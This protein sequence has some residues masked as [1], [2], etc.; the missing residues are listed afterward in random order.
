MNDELSSFLF[1]SSLPLSLSS[2]THTHTHT[3][4]HAFYSDKRRRIS[5]TNGR[6]RERERKKKCRVIFSSL[7][8]E[9]G[10]TVRATCFAKQT[11]FFSSPALC[12]Y[13]CMYYMRQNMLATCTSA[14][15]CTSLV[16]YHSVRTLAAKAWKDS[17]KKLGSPHFTL[18]PALLTFGKSTQCSWRHRPHTR[19]S[20]SF[21][22]VTSSHATTDD[23]I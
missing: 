4:T 12:T 19:S 11:I 16:T 17:K 5:Y 18:P 10:D 3:H 22:M 20:F 9:I 23:S 8:K 21:S 2:P 15:E 14:N 13:F 6:E 1:L 7:T